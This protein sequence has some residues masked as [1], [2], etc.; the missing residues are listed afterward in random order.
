M[1]LRRSSE[2][3]E[4]PKK[5]PSNPGPVTPISSASPRM[6]LARAFAFSSDF[7][8]AASASPRLARR[9]SACAS[10]TAI[11]AFSASN[12]SMRASVSSAFASKTTG[13]SCVSRQ[14]PATSAIC[15]IADLNFEISSDSAFLLAKLACRLSRAEAACSCSISIWKSCCS[16]SAHCDC[17]PAH[18]DC[19]LAHSD[20]K[21]AHCDCDKLSRS[22]NSSIL[23]SGASCFSSWMSCRLFLS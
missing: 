17:R 7:C 3:F 1:S 23:C 12:S 22:S 2:D 16:F 4:P 11:L 9:S 18:C 5:A 14:A 21:P 6:P 19:R 8:R 20:C 15:F 10:A 13:S